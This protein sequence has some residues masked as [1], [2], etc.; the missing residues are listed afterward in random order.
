VNIFELQ[1]TIKSLLKIK[2]SSKEKRSPFF[3]I[4]SSD[5]ETPAITATTSKPLNLLNIIHYIEEKLDE[6]ICLTD[7]A[8][9]ANLSK[10]HFCR[11]LKKYIG[12]S[13]MRFVT[14]LKVGRAKELLQREDLNITEVALEV[15][16][17]DHSSFVR[18]FKKLTGVT[19]KKYRDSIK[20]E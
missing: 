20:I 13:P 1:Q 5:N 10:H 17:N 18:G 11:N 15:G 12:M 8:R 14:F 16:F 3:P 9:K 19:P 7:C 6:K 4:I 2:R